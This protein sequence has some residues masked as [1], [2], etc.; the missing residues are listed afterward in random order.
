MIQCVWHFK[1]SL[2]HFS[3]QEDLFW[4]A[5]HKS[6]FTEIVLL[7]HICMPSN[8]YNSDACTPELVMH[9][10]NLQLQKQIN[11]HFFKYMDK[12][13]W[14]V[15]CN[16]IL[17]SIYYGKGILVYLEAHFSCIYIRQNCTVFFSMGS[18]YLDASV[19]TIIVTDSDLHW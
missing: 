12:V 15:T 19:N 5:V 2:L 11:Q 8:L 6:N 7:L 14:L 9:S 18:T 16:C 13:L 17:A 3:L 10:S 4:L 1:R